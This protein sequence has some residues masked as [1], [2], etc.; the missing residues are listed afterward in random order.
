MSDGS[1]YFELGREERDPSS[2]LE[3]AGATSYPNL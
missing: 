1:A 2:K 3:M